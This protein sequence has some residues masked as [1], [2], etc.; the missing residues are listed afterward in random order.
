MT[1]YYKENKNVW[2][3]SSALSTFTPVNV[4]I[5][6]LLFLI[7]GNLNTEYVEMRMNN[8]HISS[9]SGLLPLQNNSKNVVWQHKLRK[10]DRSPWLADLSAEN[11]PPLV[12]L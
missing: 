2:G 4:V 12:E 6:A 7:R 10:P 8:C 11:E 9:V 1:Q 3:L 5:L